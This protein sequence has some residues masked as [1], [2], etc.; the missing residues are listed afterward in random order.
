MNQQWLTILMS[1]GIELDQKLRQ[2]VQT[3]KAGLKSQLEERGIKLNPVDL[4]ALLEEVSPAASNAALSYALDI[5]RPFSSGMGLRV[6][7][8]ADN[9]IEVI[10]PNRQRNM[11]EFKVLHEGAL[12]TAA[13][14]TV[15]ILWTRHAP[16]GV[17]EISLAKMETE[18]FGN[19]A[20]EVRMRFELPEAS[21]EEALG[22]LRLNREAPSECEVSCFDVN[23]QVLAKFKI[24]VNL[25]HTPSLES[26]SEE[27]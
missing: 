26:T 6:S 2:Q 17:F 9:H 12:Q 27:K 1:K 14:E 25:K 21:R 22:L 19:S 13:L 7:K 5:L 10:I 15:K 23:D 3:A 16:M 18:I 20:E 24:N 8:L 11:S 4:A